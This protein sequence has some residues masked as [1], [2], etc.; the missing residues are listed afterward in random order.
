[1]RRASRR[2][3]ATTVRHTSARQGLEHDVANGGDPTP[4]LADI[5]SAEH[6]VRTARLVLLNSM[7]MDGPAEFELAGE[8]ASVEAAGTLEDWQ[9]EADEKHPDLLAL[10]LAVAAAHRGGQ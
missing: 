7:G 10:R 1:M 6:E 5:A 3:V 2:T 4:I 8:P 9:R